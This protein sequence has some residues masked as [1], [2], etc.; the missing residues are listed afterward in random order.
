MSRF[1]LVIAVALV[2]LACVASNTQAA[3]LLDDDFDGY[4]NQAAFVAAWPASGT[5]T[6]TNGNSGVL[7]TDQAFSLPN[8]VRPA[9]VAAGTTAG[10]RNDRNFG[11]T[12]ASV[13]Q[14]IEWSFR[15]YDV[16]GTAAAYREYS[17]MVNGAGTGT[18]DIIAMGLNNN[19]A[20]TFYMARMT[21]V[22]GGSGS[23]A[24]FRLDNVGAPVR[25]TG[26]HELKALVSLT[27]V[28]FF[29]DG[30]AAK[31]VAL[32]VVGQGKS[33]ERIRMGSNLS[34]TLRPYFDD[35]FVQTVIPEPTSLAVM[36]LGAMALFRRRRVA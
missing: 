25:S 2:A 20:S 26:W 11:E 12:A 7:T 34:T 15:Y 17:E 29:V 31:T 35:Q 13:S 6:T 8:G 14:Q 28:E 5:G 21:S 32:P 18:A 22:D 3:I 4:A 33:Y 9:P 19:I 16:N 27:Q 24:F 1:T 23:S 36:G 30:F 10:F